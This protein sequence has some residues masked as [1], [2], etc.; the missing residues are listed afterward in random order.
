MN[1]TWI[2]EVKLE[3]GKQAVLRRGDIVYLCPPKYALT[4]FHFY[5]I[6]LK[7]QSK[8]AL[9]F[10]IAL[11]YTVLKAVKSVFRKYLIF[12]CQGPIF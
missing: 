5:S 2:N 7:K 6:R 4:G 10:T 11:Q 1:G 12:T 8:F 3:S 9:N